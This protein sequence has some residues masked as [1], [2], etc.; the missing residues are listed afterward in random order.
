MLF[1]GSFITRASGSVGDV[2]A[3][4]NRG[5]QYLRERV[6]PVQPDTTA[7]LDA[8]SAMSQASQNWRNALDDDERSGW[9]LYAAN[10][11]RVNALG[12]AI[13]LTGHQQFCR[14]NMLRHYLDKS[15][16]LVPPTVF[17][18][19]VMPVVVDATATGN[20]SPGDV[21]VE[22]EFETGPGDGD[23]L[24]FAGAPQHSSIKWFRGPWAFVVETV[25]EF[26]GPLVVQGVGQVGDGV[27]VYTR[28][29]LDDG[30]LS[31]RSQFGPI[32]VE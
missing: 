26:F 3:S 27:W 1:S 8:R 20:P 2:V 4:H 32:T 12:A 11:P 21:D 13:V 17:G 7:Q 16:A 18:Y 19:P 24:V 9:R 14:S 6:D 28:L 22:L 23:Y 25:T 29:M 15:L 30:R 5:G 31:E 10:S